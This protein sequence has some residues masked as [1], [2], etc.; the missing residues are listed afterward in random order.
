MLQI[1]ILHCI[2]TLIR[3]VYVS[4]IFRTK[5]APLYTTALYMAGAEA[6]TLGDLA[7]FENGEFLYPAVDRIISCTWL[8][9]WFRFVWG[10][11]L[12]CTSMILYYS[13]ISDIMRHQRSMSTRRK[14]RLTLGITGSMYLAAMV[15]A[16]MQPACDRVPL[17]VRVWLTVT[18]V[19]LYGIWAVKTHG[20][21]QL[22]GRKR[23]AHIALSIMA[24]TGIFCIATGFADPSR[25]LAIVRWILIE[26]T[27]TAILIFTIGGGFGPGM[28]M[29]IVPRPMRVPGSTNHAAIE[30]LKGNRVLCGH[31]LAFV[32]RAIDFSMDQNSK[33]ATTQDEGIVLTRHDVRRWTRE[34]MDGPPDG[35]FTVPPGILVILYQIPG[36]PV[37]QQ[38][39]GQAITL[40]AME[41][42]WTT[43]V[44]TS[45]HYTAYAA[46][47]A[48]HTAQQSNLRLRGF[49]GDEIVLLDATQ[50]T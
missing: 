26:I 28:R 20:G 16:C 22:Y 39:A 8:S 19:L 15:S 21:A 14:Q 47:M 49:D 6:W 43:F 25:V 1:F 33:Q 18:C 5:G 42:I 2:C 35:A 48:R 36:D 38:K 40:D 12:V 41:Q 31:F 29:P 37:W 32:N 17:G 27:T 10:L 3:A 44:T 46:V 7:V 9:V 50:N 24:F 13:E 4:W 11:G 23:Y 30:Q 34:V 45:I